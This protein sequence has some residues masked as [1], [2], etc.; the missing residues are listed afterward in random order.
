M[1]GRQ[2]GCALA[3]ASTLFALADSQSAAALWGSPTWRRASMATSW[4]WRISPLSSV[5]LG[6]LVSKHDAQR[7]A[8]GT[9]A[10]AGGAETAR[11][12]ARGRRQTWR[13][14]AN[15]S[16]QPRWPCLLSATAAVVGLLL[17][18]EGQRF[19]PAANAQPIY[20][21]APFL[22]ALWA[23]LVLSEPVPPLR[24]RRR[25]DRSLITAGHDHGRRRAPARHLNRTVTRVIQ[26]LCG[27]SSVPLSASAAPRPTPSSAGL[28]A[29]P[30]GRSDRGSTATGAPIGVDEAGDRV[31]VCAPATARASG[32]F[33]RCA[34]A[35]H[36]GVLM[37]HREERC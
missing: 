2:L 30:G 15:N 21:A 10:D 25:R 32:T 33:A 31:P 34:V 8:V 11:S 1:R 16:H 20:A 5:R 35:R 29:R 37:R 22:S 19:V 23:Y 27:L 12:A 4:R 13:G 14:V 18:Y 9:A 6:S 17:Q 36:V 28:R 3:L 26:K 7:L 24:R